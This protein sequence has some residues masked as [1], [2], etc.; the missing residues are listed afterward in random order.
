M[1]LR[2][3]VSHGSL[4]VRVEGDL[5]VRGAEAFR[6]QVEA[7]LGESGAARLVVNLQHV[8]FIDSTGLGALLG[9]Y[10]R[11]RDAGLEMA[12][13]APPPAARAVLEMAGV[14]TLMPVFASDA[15]ALG[16]AAT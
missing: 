16:V 1:R 15:E 12:L 11:L 3:R 4:L 10:R 5:D 9:R 6:R 14:P 7:W 8:G 13:V 2:S